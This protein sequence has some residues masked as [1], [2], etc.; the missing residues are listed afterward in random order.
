MVNLTVPHPASSARLRDQVAERGVIVGV[1]N[2]ASAAGEEAHR[3]VAVKAIETGGWCAADAL[4]FVDQLQTVTIRARYGAALEFVQ[5][6]RVAGQVLVGHEERC[7][8]GRNGL[9][10]RLPSPS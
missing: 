9:S 8:L 7:R 6:L 10:T 5:H 4:A 3:A 1:C 2:C